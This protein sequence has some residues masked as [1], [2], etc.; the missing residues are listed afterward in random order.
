[1][2]GINEKKEQIHIFAIERECVRLKHT[3]T[4]AHDLLYLICF[5]M[6]ALNICTDAKTEK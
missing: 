1:M 5:E 6:C 2:T 3:N 4:H